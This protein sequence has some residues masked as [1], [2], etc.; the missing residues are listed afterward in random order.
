MQPLKRHAPSSTVSVPPNDDNSD[1]DKC[2]V[3]Y[4]DN[5]PHVML[6]P[7][8]HKLC[9]IC[10]VRVKVCAVCRLM[11]KTTDPD[12]ERAQHLDVAGH[13]Q[14]ISAAVVKFT[15][16]VPMSPSCFDTDV[17]ELILQIDDPILAIPATPIRN[18]VTAHSSERTY[19]ELTR[20]LKN[21][22]SVLQLRASN[23][24]RLDKD[25]IPKPQAML[26][27]AMTIPIPKSKTRGGEGVRNLRSIFIIPPATAIVLPRKYV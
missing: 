14:T 12:V 1:T 18:L 6:L 3:C 21:E 22:A 17:D 19:T 5:V 15:D 7:C 13:A 27:H 16:T 10:A 23:A 4:E 25:Y 24:E 26:P 8:R 11:I 2:S 20:R 9:Y